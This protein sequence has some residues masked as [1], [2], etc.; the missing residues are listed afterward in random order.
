MKIYMKTILNIV[1][2]LRVDKVTIKAFYVGR[3]MLWS[4]GYLLDPGHLDDASV[5]EIDGEVGLLSNPSGVKHHSQPF[6]VPRGVY[7]EPGVQALGKHKHKDK[8]KK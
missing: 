8:H 3:H 4:L 2:K 6:L 1:N 5:V 7:M